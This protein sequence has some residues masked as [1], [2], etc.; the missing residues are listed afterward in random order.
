M[1]ISFGVVI[2]EE[3]IGIIE[4]YDSVV[5]ILILIICGC[6][7]LI[8]KIVSHTVETI[9]SESSSKKLQSHINLLN[10]RS[11]AYEIL[12]KKELEYYDNISDFISEVVVLIQ[13][14][15]WN[16]TKTENCSD[17][18]SK[19]KYKKNSLDNLTNILELIPKTK[20]DALV[21]KNYSTKEIVDAHT[22]LICF[23]QNNAKKISNIIMKE[24]FSSENKSKLRKLTD[25][26]LKISAYL[27]GLVQIRQKELSE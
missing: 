20:K 27:S 15:Y 7:F 9:F 8:K 22:D 16:Y 14:V 6:L 25:E 11:M 19:K 12:L 5:F 26:V 17:S 13:D 24:K 4:K 18:E 1:I 2:V 10:R 21:L 23:I 3:I